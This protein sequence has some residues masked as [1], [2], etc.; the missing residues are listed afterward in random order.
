[1]IICITF[2]IK[3]VIFTTFL[4]GYLLMVNQ[5]V[6]EN[7]QIIE[8]VSNYF[9]SDQWK[10]LLEVL[11]KE[12]EAVHHAHIYV[13]TNIHP[14]S[15]EE[16]I[17]GYFK[18]HGME[19]H[20]KI[21]IF[22]SGQVLNSGSIHGIEPEGLPHF[23]FIWSYSSENTLVPANKE[24]NVEYWGEKYMEA[25]LSQYP[26]KTTVNEQELQEVKD[27]FRS[28]A[29]NDYCQLNEHPDVVHIHANVETSVHPDIIREEALKV[30]KERGWEI[31]EAVHVAFQMRG[32]MH[33][34]IVFIANTPEKIFDIAWAYNPVVNL[35]PSTKYWLMPEN[36]TYDA[37]TM[38]ELP[39]L[40]KKDTYKLLSLCEIEEVINNI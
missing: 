21:E 20:R 23:D 11:Q 18:K 36:P 22:T 40:L 32:Q 24:N 28:K 25:F 33:G 31:E 7:R 4:G 3:V 26:F 37:R 39:L 34:K 27:Y 16:V 13:E 9:K 14:L 8:S 29:W 35:I 38:K 6:Q 30:M 5:Q 12:D 10:K 19:V 1:V 17:K 15:L 2:L